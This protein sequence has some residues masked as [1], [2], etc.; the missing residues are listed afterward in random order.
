MSLK[1]QTP[2]TIELLL[3]SLRSLILQ[4]RLLLSLAEFLSQFQT[5]SNLQW[6]HKI[7]ICFLLLDC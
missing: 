7:Q 1:I 5:L 6:I 4:Y 2:L 3:S